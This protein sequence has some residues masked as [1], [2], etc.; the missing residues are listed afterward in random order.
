MSTASREHGAISR[1]RR[2]RH[3]VAA[4]TLLL[5]CLLIPGGT[6][7]A[8]SPLAP[9]RQYDL[10]NAR[11]EL[12]FDLEQKKVIGQVTHTLAALQD[13]LRQ[14]DFDSVELEIQ[15]VRVNGADAHFTAD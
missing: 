5:V 11:I 7:R 10:Q 3:W 4:P 15:N 1:A 12:R 6:S 8:D 14:F 2:R 13:G 9:T